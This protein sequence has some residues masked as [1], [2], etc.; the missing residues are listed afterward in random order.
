MLSRPSRSATRP[1]VPLPAKG[2]RT[3]QGITSAAQEQDGCQP[4]VFCSLRGRSPYPSFGRSVSEASY[5][6]RLLLL[7]F[8]A[9]PFGPL[10]TKAPSSTT[11]THGVPHAPQQPRSLVPALMHGSTRAGGKVAKWA[12]E[13]GAGPRCQTLRRL[14]DE[15]TSA[16]ASLND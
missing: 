4:R 11:R 1:V 15:R 13:Y 7:A 5:A 3:V 12:S 9:S 16:V 8:S 2:S 14:R 6:W 10:A